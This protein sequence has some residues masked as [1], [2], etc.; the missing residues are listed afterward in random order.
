MIGNVI[1]LNKRQD[2]YEQ[3][4]DEFKEIKSIQLKRFPAIENI[5]GSV[6]C[7]MSH[8]K[9]LRD[10]KHNNNHIL[11]LEDDCKIVDKSNFDKVWP[12]IRNWLDNNHD[13]WD[14]FVGGCSFIHNNKVEWI[15][16]DLNLVLTSN[17][18]TTHFI[19]YNNNFIDKVISC[20]PTMKNFAIDKLYKIYD[21][22]R[23]VV[24]YNF[25][26]TQI[27]NYSDIEKK[28]VNYDRHFNNCQQKIHDL[29]NDN[30][31]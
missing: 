13:K 8:Q 28:E 14:I 24:P 19:Y 5:K 26:V 31:I 21:N 27:T 12:E 25:I 30:I 6:G 7:C 4:M 16:K 29:L 17:Y 23:V 2:R 15:N 3:I 10:N 9:I 11:I 22:I 18:G 20:C 1:N